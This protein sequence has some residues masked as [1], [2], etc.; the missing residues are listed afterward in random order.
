[1]P[2]SID[3]GFTGDR[4]GGSKTD[5]YVPAVSVSNSSV[6]IATGF[7]LGGRN[8]GALNGLSIKADLVGKLTPYLGLIDHQA[9]KKLEKASLSITADEAAS[10]DKAVKPFEVASL[11][12][13]YLASE[14][15][16]ASLI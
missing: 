8:I 5:G 14:K 2:I 12:A 16:S 7:D 11:K 4:L 3:Y 15:K 9:K 1:M 6:T 13:K 10:I